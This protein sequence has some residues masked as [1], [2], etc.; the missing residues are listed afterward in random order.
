MSATPH[1]LQLSEILSAW[2]RGPPGRF[3]CIISYMDPV[4]GKECQ[5]T[6]D[7]EV[8]QVI[9]ASY[10]PNVTH[11]PSVPPYITEEPVCMQFSEYRFTN[12]FTV[13]V[14]ILHSELLTFILLQCVQERPTPVTSVWLNISNWIYVQEQ[15]YSNVARLQTDRC[16]ACLII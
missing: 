15:F 13:S 12:M 14:I 9:L 3:W 6:F 10:W 16:Q 5:N 1:F 4:W 7:F 8:S 2:D 11:V